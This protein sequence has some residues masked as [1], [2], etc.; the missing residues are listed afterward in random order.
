MTGSGTSGDT[1]KD[2]ETTQTTEGNVS[3]TT[4]TQS[5]VNVGTDPD[6]TTQ[7]QSKSNVFPHSTTFVIFLLTSQKFRAPQVAVVDLLKI[8]RVAR[9]IE[10]VHIFVTR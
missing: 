6:V 8:F 4:D 10:V 7:S 5:T 2:T 9:L 1:N 3:G